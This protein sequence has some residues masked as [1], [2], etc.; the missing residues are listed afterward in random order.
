[1][2]VVRCS[3]YDLFE[4]PRGR[5]EGS[6]LYRHVKLVRTDAVAVAPDGLFA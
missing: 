6:G 3:P 1:L 2:I 5:Y 4:L